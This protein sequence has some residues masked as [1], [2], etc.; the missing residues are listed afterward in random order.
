MPYIEQKDRE[1]FQAALDAMPDIASAGELNY[2]VTQLARKYLATH[3]LRY[4][5]L[6]DISGALTN[7]NLELYRRVAAGYE[8]IK[9]AENGDVY[10]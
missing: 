7:A 3:G 6:N 5:Y 4:Q 1:K 10:Q 9:V 2:I 8:D